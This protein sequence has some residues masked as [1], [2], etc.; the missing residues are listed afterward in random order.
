MSIVIVMVDL[1]IYPKDKGN[2]QKMMNAIIGPTRAHAS[3]LHCDFYAS[4]LNDDEMTL[5]Q[6]WKSEADLENHIR[7]QE[8][9]NILIAMEHSIT[10]PEIRICKA[11]STE[12]VE[13]IKRVR[14]KGKDERA[15]ELVGGLEDR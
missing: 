11:E 2:I 1:K 12:G 6:T 15:E 5:L 13:Y 7:S 14:L 10:P 8:F 4:T 9:R 3:C